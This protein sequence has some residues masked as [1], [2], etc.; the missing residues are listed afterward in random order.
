MKIKLGSKVTDSITGFSGVA[1]A[2]AEYLYSSTTIAVQS[3][4]LHDGKPLSRVWID[5]Q[6]LLPADIKREAADFTP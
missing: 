5:E 4:E 1:L 3:E 2:R 6:R